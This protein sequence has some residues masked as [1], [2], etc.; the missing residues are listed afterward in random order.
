[1]SYSS[2][3]LAIKRS[4]IKRLVKE[5]TLRVP[6]SWAAQMKIANELV[7]LYP[8]L[9][10]WSRSDNGFQVNSLAYF[11]TEEGASHLKSQYAVFHFVY[12][13]LKPDP[14]EVDASEQVQSA[15]IRLPKSQ[16]RTVAEYFGS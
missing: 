13:P 4:A 10:F 9:S 16:P 11:K 5:E 7:A 6:G 12:A 14:V 8:D 2:S 3:A 15:P 1:M